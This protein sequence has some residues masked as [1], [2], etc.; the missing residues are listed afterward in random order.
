MNIKQ[1]ILYT[2]VVV[3]CGSI[4]TQTHAALS[5]TAYLEFTAGTKYCVYG[6]TVPDNCK[7]GIIRTNGSYFSMDNNGN[8]LI[9]PDE[10]KSL[11]PFNNLRLGQIQLAGGSHVGDPDGSESPNIDEAWPFF[12]NTG[13]HQATQPITIAT[14]DLAGTVTLDMAGWSV[15]WNGISDIPM[16]GD[17]A[18]FGTTGNTGI[19]SLTC[20]SAC[21]HGDTFILDYA[22]QVPKNDPSNF[23]GVPYTLHLE[24]TI[25][26]PNTPPT[27]VADTISVN[28]GESASIDVTTN[29][30]SDP[31]NDAL[32]VGTLT[33]G[34]TGSVTGTGTTLATYTS[35]AADVNN[36]TAADTF[37]YTVSDGALE[38]I[39]AATV[40][41]SIN[42]F[43]VAVDDGPIG[44]T[45][46]A[47]TSIAVL[48]NDTDANDS[49]D[50]TSISINSNPTNGTAVAGADGIV[51]YTNDG[52]L[53]AD[54]FTYTV[55][56]TN[57][58]VSITPAT[59]TISVEADPLPT[60]NGTTLSP[61][62]DTSITFVVD[63]FA[64]AG[65]AGTP[66][67][68]TLD[69]T[70]VAITTDVTNGATGI[71]AVTGVIT[72]TP[73]AGYTGADTFSY[74]VAD[75][76]QTCA[77][78]AVTINVISTNIAPTAVDDSGLF[79][80]TTTNTAINVD[81]KANDTDDDDI[82]NSDVT[83]T[84]N[85][86][87][88]STNVETDGTVTYTPN[89]GYSG[90]DSF[91]YNLT[92]TEGATSLNAAVSMII[93]ADAPAVSDGTL[94]PGDTANTAGSTDGRVT[95]EEIGI[96][97]NG[98]S[99]TQGIAQS[100]IGGCFDFVISGLTGG[101]DAQVV[102]PLSIAI[103]APSEG[104]TLLYRK[105]TSTGWQ[106]FDTSG[107]NAIASA[108]GIGSGAS[109][110]CPATTSTSYT[111]NL[112]EGDRCL[113][114]TIV[115]NGPND[116]DPADGTVADPSGI[117]ESV[118]IDTRV[119]GTDGCSMSGNSVNANQR[120][121]WWLV[122]GFMGLLGLFRLKRKQG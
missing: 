50:I 84:N 66:D 62:Q 47:A 25:F 9:D 81:V 18:N 33:Q 43:P 49:I 23:G 101:A 98:S 106:N 55:A 90:T 96:E 57:G 89:T 13:M 73:D 42:S 32:T 92:D 120:A 17:P 69:L 19:A 78:T 14:D 22:A 30:S 24:G 105:L 80:T 44:A 20:T 35:T 87:N 116:T 94:T 112:T 99:E 97:D 74:T 48:Q 1:K 34:S 86:S 8:G 108:A 82:A 71:D 29:G 65:G 76:T 46:S 121:D 91:T 109:T 26:V 77:P 56:D 72:Y 21:E 53:G 2:A 60:C 52:T 118:N 38:S 51:T 104:N 59:V 28:A 3:A 88:G 68:K 70:S 58:A 11:T 83:I 16:R 31:E 40:T 5:E 6:G 79:T 75:D 7:F 113:R 114:L 41:V 100:C 39:A 115:D 107:N 15:T 27:A 45:A 85:A 110:V 61:N 95:I 12:T 10:E 102:L 63:D 67:A 103:P 37:T 54:S 64:T 111:P 4:S 93:A 122:A 117:A 36:A 119:S